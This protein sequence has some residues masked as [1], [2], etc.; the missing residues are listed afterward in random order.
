MSDNQIKALKEEIARLERE[1]EIKALK[2][3]IARL[4]KI[5]A[6]RDREHSGVDR[7]GVP[8]NKQRG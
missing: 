1:K 5:K 4:K 6:L 2:E 3:E 7:S 8:V